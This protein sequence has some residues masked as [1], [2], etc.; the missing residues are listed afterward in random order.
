MRDSLADR[1]NEVL[2][3]T[4]SV[5]GI[6]IKRSLDRLEFRAVTRDL[7]GHFGFTLLQ[8]DLPHAAEVTSLPYHHGDP[9]DRM[10]VAQARLDDLVLV[11]SDEDIATYDVA[12][13]W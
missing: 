11:F 2:V 6:A 5:W 1:E 9:F 4:A 10:L 12:T 8:I 13:T 7:L 3:S